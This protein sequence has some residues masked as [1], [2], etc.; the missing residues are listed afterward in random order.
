MSAEPQMSKTTVPPLKYA[1]NRWHWLV[2][3][4]GEGYRCLAEW[5]A[6]RRLWLPPG[7]PAADPEDMWK[8]GW[9]WDAPVPD[10]SKAK[11]GDTCVFQ[12]WMFAL[13]MQ[14]QSVL[15]LA[16]R[17]PDGIGKMHPTKR[18]VAR[19]RASVLKAA[20]YGRA[21]RVDEDTGGNTFMTLEKFSDDEHWFKI[22][23]DFFDNADDLPHHYY[24]H[25]THGAQIIGY[26]HPMD[27]MRQR[28]GRFYLIVAKE[29]HLG[30]ES[31]EQ[32]D[33]RLN[34]WSQQHWGEAAE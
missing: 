4:R 10:R 12:G 34:D 7:A 19:Y 5:S 30:V 9:R 24:M 1:G 11:D 25:L 6:N 22:V 17:G 23:D 18:I 14:Q 26:K 13:S 27:I 3:A 2:S 28:W 31:E 32:M 20:Y 16:C 15:V 21:T 29:L 33:L 8:Q